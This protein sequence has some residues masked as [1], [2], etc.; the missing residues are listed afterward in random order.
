[1]KSN[2]QTTNTDQLILDVSEADW[3]KEMRKGADYYH[4]VGVWVAIIFDPIFGITDYINIPESWQHVFV[5]RCLVALITFGGL[6]LY[7]RKI[8]STYL[9][10]AIP[11]ALISLQNAYT[12][13]LIG[14][15][16]I[17]G[18]NLNYLALFL[19]ASLF[20]LWPLA[21]SIIAI[22]A[23]FIATF[24]FVSLNENV[25]IEE[26]LV[27][28][29]VLLATGAIFTIF[30]IQARFGLRLKEVKARL[31][32]TKSLKVTAE[33]KEEIEQQ[34][35]ELIET[36]NQLQEAK[37]KIEKMNTLLVGYN[38]QLEDEVKQRTA[39]LSKANREMDQLV[40][41]LSH[42]FRTPLVNVQGLIDL[43]SSTEDPNM[44]KVFIEKMGTSVS[45]FDEILRD[46]MNYAV[47]WD[48][49]IKPQ[50]ISIKALILNK[51]KHFEYIHKNGMTLEIE[52]ENE[53]VWL[54]NSCHEKL[55]VILYSL[56]SNAVR[57]NAPNGKVTVKAEK[58][59]NQLVVQMID[60][61][62]GIDEEH[63]P[64][65]FD[66]FYRGNAKSQGAR[67]GLYIAKGI[68]TQLGGFIDL[69]SKKGEGTTVTVGLP[70]N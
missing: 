63:L 11:F 16:D 15:E 46:M 25:P 24:A 56:L 35:N 18:H 9:L 41:S 55:R 69:Q 22:S 1:M 8:I 45:R 3:R 19:G 7:R 67:M 58:S 62:E 12:Y 30:M 64:R 29:G 31:A 49:E 50:D 14:P 60:T 70:L 23:S 28:G 37:G 2:N 51:W 59:Q 40:Y 33:Q 57:Y 34:H 53:E 39:K 65:V 44:L 27:E 20:L 32:L 43:A 48:E 61:G 42:D 36:T 10:V 21:Y 5:L 4:K 52:P 54:I 38:D 13:A 26:F 17:L 66:M 68:I 47:Y 6:L